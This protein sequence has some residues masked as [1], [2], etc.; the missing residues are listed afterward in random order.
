MMADNI[1]WLSKRN[2]K[3][4]IWASVSHNMRNFDAK[5]LKAM[6]WSSDTKFMG[7]YLSD[8]IG[9]DNMFHIAF[10]GY[11]GS[12]TDIYKNNEQRKF[13]T[14]SDESIEASL[15]R[16]CI[17]YGYLLLNDTNSPA[18]LKKTFQS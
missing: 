12:Y 18:W 5:L 8:L 14:P 9:S 6:G 13:N 1:K 3:I 16:A 17:K 7:E 10:T 2:S 15:N 4:I 11:E